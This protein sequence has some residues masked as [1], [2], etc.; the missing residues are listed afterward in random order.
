MKKRVHS[1][2][3]LFLLSQSL[4][5]ADRTVDKTFYH[6]RNADTR[7]WSHYPENAERN[8][9]HI[10]FD[11]PQPEE[12]EILT[13]R[14]QGTKQTWKVSL[15]EK[16]IG[17]LQRDHNHLEHGIVLPKGTLKATG[18][19]LEIYTES[20]VSD[21]IEVGDFALWKSRFRV[22]P[23]LTAELEKRRGFKRVVP[24]LKKEL[25]LVCID[26]GSGKAVPCRFTIVDK[27]T[28]VLAF[29]AVESDDRLA[30]REGVVYSLDGK[31]TVRLDPEKSYLIYAGR[32]FEYS[33]EVEEVSP[34]G[35]NQLTFTLEREVETP[36][37]VACDTHLHTYEFDRHG[38]CTLTERILS[39]AGEGVE[40]PVSTGHDKHI[41]YDEE[42]IRIGAH[43]WMTPV[44][45]CEITTSLGHF[46]SFPVKPE[47][48]PAE[49]KLR[50]WDQI[51]QN[52]YST[53]DVKVCILNHGRD[54]HRKFTPLAPENFDSATGTFLHGRKLRANGM[55]ILNSGATQTDPMELVNDWF[56]LLKSGH[57][58]A[59]VGASDSHTVNFAI[60][61]QGRTYLEVPDDSDP[62]TIDVDA[63]VDSFVK[64]RTWVSFGLMALLEPDEKAEGARIRVLGPAWTSADRVRIFRNGKLV[65]DLQINPQDGAKPG[66]KFEASF[67]Y[68]DLNATKGDFLCAVATGPGISGAWWPMMPPYQPDSP[69][70]ER[71]VFGMSPAVWLK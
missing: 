36:G 56:A 13:L 11:V 15:N 40:L 7:E 24:D 59:A 8:V 31:V 21:D 41:A 17:S 62:A 71:Y 23:S 58:I 49:H 47:A 53:P 66:E 6:V 48:K 20:E 10:E 12:Y 52:I 68:A 57:P 2:L 63:A 19:V 67:T 45:G 27:E 60:P 14:Q 55:E 46:N 37:L 18:N 44:T 65:Q 16:E 25:S 32:G 29:I 64:G 54:V 70:L 50:N 4:C 28:G 9:L 30:V 61:G 69:N 43:E 34:E 26:K 22:D 3:F 42:A 39:A 5:G 35:E 33:L 1:L 51:F 38:D